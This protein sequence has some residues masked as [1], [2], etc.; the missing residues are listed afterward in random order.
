MSD[1]LPI[2][3]SRE[4]KYSGRSWRLVEDRYTLPSGASHTHPMIVHPGA[5]VILPIEADGSCILVRQWRYSLERFFL[6]LPAGTMTP[7]EDPIVC[8]ARELREEIGR[9]AAAIEP[10]GII[11]PAPGFCD[12]IQHCFIARDLVEKREACD[13]DEI[14]ET[15]TL[16]P[17][18]IEEAIRDGS[19]S[20]GK[21]IALY[22]RAKLAGAFSGK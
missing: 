19:L 1:N 3:Q 10:I 22:F 6:E 9:D 14:I 5:V 11:H 20:D 4:L 18:L 21:S 8:A 15:I 17:D 7:G 2:R 12:E 16:T 13:D